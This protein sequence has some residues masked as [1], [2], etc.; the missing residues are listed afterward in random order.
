MQLTARSIVKEE[1]HVRSF[2]DQRRRVNRIIVSYR[3]EDGEEYRK[4]FES[5]PD[6]LPFV[7][8]SGTHEQLEAAKYQWTE[9][10]MAAAQEACDILGQEP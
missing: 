9:E 5:A 1:K 4:S 6:R 3:G 8:A 7:P 10:G 2:H